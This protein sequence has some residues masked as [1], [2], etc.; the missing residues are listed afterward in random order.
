MPNA[1][2]VPSSYN[3][4]NLLRAIAAVLGVTAK[5]MSEIDVPKYYP[6]SI[7]Y[8]RHLQNTPC[9]LYLQIKGAGNQ[10]EYVLSS[11]KD[12]P[13]STLIG[14]F[15]KEGITNL[16]VNSQERL[17]MV[18]KISL[19]L[20]LIV[21]GTSNVSTSAKSDAIS[22]GFS[23]VAT[24]IFD[25]SEAVQEIVAIAETCSK[26]MDK[27]VSE[28]SSMQALVNM[29]MQNQEGYIYTHSMLTAYVAKHIIKHVSW[30]GDSHIERINF[31][32]FFHDI[33]L[34]PV[35][36]KYPKARAEEDLLF[37]EMLTNEE[38]ELVLNHARLAGE[39]ITKYKKCPSGVDTLIKQHHGMGN[40]VG[41]AT[42]FSDNISP[43]SKLFMIAED[44]SEYY[45]RQ[46]YKNKN[47][48]INL[49][50][51]LS[52]LH[53]KYSK[54]TYKKIIEPLLTLKV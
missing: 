46:K 10:F 27:V 14:K 43:L 48:K 11:V 8:L 17:L 35:Y 12:A 40:G 25:N 4:Q 16:F 19:S 1:T 52:E 3:L 39:Q 2:I 49:P 54:H 45:L 9:D 38:K 31:M 15:Q 24:Q 5:T 28:I 6:I 44:F 20:A 41:F 50:E 36:E 34:V 13:I 47:F 26:V 7:S 51:Y 37:G 21:S 33:Y 23:F 29:L 53:L 30:G 32:V 18:N 22:A 42:D